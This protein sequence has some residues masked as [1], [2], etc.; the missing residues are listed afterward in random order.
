MAVLC[1]I[2]LIFCALQMVTFIID[3]YV[4][5][6]GDQLVAVLSWIGHMSDLY[7]THLIIR[8]VLKQ[9]TELLRAN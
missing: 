2:P 7:N 5:L 6:L 4:W 1:S 8:G 9:G 3:K